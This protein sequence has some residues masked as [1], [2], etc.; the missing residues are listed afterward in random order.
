MSI[1]TTSSSY[2][3]WDDQVNASISRYTP[4]TGT[5]D[6]IDTRNVDGYRQG[7]EL[8]NSSDFFL[9][10]QPKV[11]G[12]SFNRFG[13]ISHIQEQ[14]I[15]GQASSF[16]DYTGVRSF[17]DLPK[18]DPV[19]YVT[20]G[21]SYPLPIYFNRGPQENADAV[22]ELIP[23]PDRR[24][25]DNEGRDRA[26]G[27]KGELMEGSSVNGRLYGNNRIVDYAYYAQPTTTRPFLDEGEIFYGDG[28]Q[29]GAVRIDGYV[30]DVVTKITPFNDQ[31]E[32]EYVLKTILA[33][34]NNAAIT[35]SLLSMNYG[36]QD[37]IRPIGARMMTAGWS[38]YGPES[39]LTGTDSIAFGG[40]KR[41][42]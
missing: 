12:G 21:A 41:G 19:G 3:P 4:N 38:Y 23:I 17:D 8:R 15:Y 14:A 16:A 10:T 34:P 5:T 20:L 39:S 42:S 13:G 22:I 35:G 36:M 33:N 18:F 29:D 9:S 26:K 11:W 25:P 37:D 6:G 7:A 28:S 31:T 1:W 24:K 40:W 30:S 32:A 27:T 2:A